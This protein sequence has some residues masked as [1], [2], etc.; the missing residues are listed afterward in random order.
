MLELKLLQ[1]V[2]SN[3]FHTVRELISEGV[4]VNTADRNGSTPLHKACLVIENK[5]NYSDLEV[6]KCLLKYNANVNALDVNGNAPLESLFSFDNTKIEKAKKVV[7]FL[8]PYSDF[9]LGY[10]PLKSAFLAQTL[11]KSLWVILLEHFAKLQALDIS[12]HENIIDSILKKSYYNA[13]FKKCKEELCLAKK[14]KICDSWLTF[15]DILLA[16]SKKLK[17]YAGNEELVDNFFNSNCFKMFPIYGVS[18]TKNVNNG[19]KRRNLFDKSSIKLTE[20]L[21][22]LNPNHL[23]VRDILDCIL[24]KKDLIKFCKKNQY[25]SFF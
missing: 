8:I 7:R 21:P 4:D 14:T 11:N 2:E 6:I 1:A 16:S 13:Y 24:S 15:F 9:N 5:I 18:M 17:N 12:I 20:C 19:I 23:I 3:Y 22:M 25:F 10:N